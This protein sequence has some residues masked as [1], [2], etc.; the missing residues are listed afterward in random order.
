ML[1]ILDRIRGNYLK[2]IFSQNEYE[3]KVKSARF[4]K[5]SHL[6]LIMQFNILQTSESRCRQKPSKF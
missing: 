3:L 6:D 5:N 2:L 4:S 1:N